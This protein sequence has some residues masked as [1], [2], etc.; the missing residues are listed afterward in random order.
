MDVKIEITKRKVAAEAVSKRRSDK[1]R[2]PRA[3][4]EIYSKAKQNTYTAE[5]NKKRVK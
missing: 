2:F 4:V 3:R 5:S 1:G